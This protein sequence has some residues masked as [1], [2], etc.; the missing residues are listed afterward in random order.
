[1]SER[2]PIFLVTGIPGAGKTTVARLLAGRF[3]RGVH[4]EADVIH[5]LIVSGALWPDEEPRAEALEQLE[6]RAANAATL[7]ASYFDH[8]FTVV[9]DDVIVGRVRLGIYERALAGRGLSVV[10]LAPPL[11]V[12]LARDEGRGETA[13]GGIWAHLHEEQREQD[14]EADGEPDI[15]DREDDR[16]DEYVPEDAVVEDRRVV[17]QADPCSVMPDQLEQLV[18]LER[19]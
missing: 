5:G 19:E 7:A 13:T 2:A 10:V 1:M 3:E 9:I 11:E 17:V 18:A 6:L 14:A 8:G 15:R 12:A 4:I 16:P